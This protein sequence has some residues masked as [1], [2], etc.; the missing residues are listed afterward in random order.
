MCI[1]IYKAQRSAAESWD[2]PQHIIDKCHYSCWTAQH[3][4]EDPDPV[5]LAEAIMKAWAPA[6][7][8]ALHAYRQEV[9]ASA[10]H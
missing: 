4:W 9:E 7:E 3:E 1:E 10:A 2:V 6:R 5:L 8:W